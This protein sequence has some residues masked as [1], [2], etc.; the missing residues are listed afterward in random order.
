[1]EQVGLEGFLVIPIT[2]PIQ[3]YFLKEYPFKPRFLAS[4][5]NFLTVN[6]LIFKSLTLAIFITKKIFL[7]VGIKFIFK[8]FFLLLATHFN[9]ITTFP[10]FTVSYK[11]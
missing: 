8:I 3:I 1:M 7:I 2:V 5:V 10:Y 6:F 9:F 4:W 11:A